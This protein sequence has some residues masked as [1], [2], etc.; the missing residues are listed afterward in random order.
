MERGIF[1]TIC[2]KGFIKYGVDQQINALQFIQK[3]SSNWGMNIHTKKK[4]ALSFLELTDDKF[5]VIFA[6]PLMIINKLTKFMTLFLSESY[7]EIMVY[8]Y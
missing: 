1:L 2:F 4:N 8:L 7:C 3:Q 6:D 5:D